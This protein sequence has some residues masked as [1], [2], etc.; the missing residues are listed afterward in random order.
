M[1]CRKRQFDGDP[2]QKQK[3][4]HYVPANRQTVCRGLPSASRKN[5]ADEGI[6]TPTGMPTGS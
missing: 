5:G 4:Q 1:L 2:Y 3:R 6:R